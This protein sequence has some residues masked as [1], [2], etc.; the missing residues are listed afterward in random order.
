MHTGNIRTD[1]SNWVGK[2]KRERKIHSHIGKYRRK[3]THDGVESAVYPQFL[4]TCKVL[5]QVQTIA[6]RQGDLSE[7]IRII[8]C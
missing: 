3:Q 8:I 4:N 6:I 2:K 7:V 1:R 5:W